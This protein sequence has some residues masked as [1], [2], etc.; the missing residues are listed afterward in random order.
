MPREPEWSL[1]RKQ[2]ST[3]DEAKRGEGLEEEMLG[4]IG[5]QVH[6]YLASSGVQ[7]PIELL[8][9]LNRPHFFML[10]MSSSLQIWPEYM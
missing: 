5:D 1:W 8:V 9:N 10:T 3:L 7:L 4:G 6:T 2:R